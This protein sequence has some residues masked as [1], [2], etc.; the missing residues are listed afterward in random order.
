MILA[1]EFNDEPYWVEVGQ[2]YAYFA[3]ATIY[4]A[5]VIIKILGLGWKKVTGI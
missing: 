4:F 2:D 3:F 5:E 1:T